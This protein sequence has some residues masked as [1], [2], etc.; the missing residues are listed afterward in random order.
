MRTPRMGEVVIG[1]YDAIL[2]DMDGTLIDSR[3]S[4]EQAWKMWCS[5]HGLDADVVIKSMHGFRAIDT[6]R[7]H[8]PHLSASQC[9]LEVSQIES[10]EILNGASSLE[11]AGASQFL[12]ALPMGRW[13]IWPFSLNQTGILLRGHLA[14]FVS[15]IDK[16]R[17][18]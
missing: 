17:G 13:A 4:I 7:N 1:N 11:I 10:S 8:L 12:A 3:D 9:D 5:R 14:Q 16:Y 6:I 18:F 15:A 2:F